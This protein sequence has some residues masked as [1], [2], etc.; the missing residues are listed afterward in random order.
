MSKKKKEE[1]VKEVPKD[2]QD[3]VEALK[4]LINVHDLLNQAQFPGHFSK[5]VTEACDFIAEIH[6]QA[7]E[8]AKNHP[9]VALIPGLLDANKEK[10]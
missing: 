2:L 6:K 5:R 3:K 4:Q 9:D 8:E 10:K 1:P 7:V